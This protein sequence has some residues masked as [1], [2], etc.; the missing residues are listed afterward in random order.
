[1]YSYDPKSKVLEVKRIELPVDVNVDLTENLKKSYSDYLKIQLEEDLQYIAE[2]IQDAIG[3]EGK[4]KII[5]FEISEKTNFE[6]PVSTRPKTEKKKKGDMYYP[7]YVRF[8][9]NGEYVPYSEDYPILKIPYMDDF[10]VLNVDGKEKVLLSELKSLEDVSFQHK[11][12]ETQMAIVFPRTQLRIAL[13]ARNINLVLGKTKVPME[14][15]ALSMLRASGDDRDISDIMS[16]SRYKLIDAS[17]GYQLEETII[18]EMSKLGLPE[19]FMK[20]RYKMGTLRPRLNARLSIDRAIDEVLAKDVI[21]ART[22]GVMPKGT[23]LSTEEVKLLKQNFVNEIYVKYTPNVRGFNLGEDVP[24]L[25][26]PEGFYMSDD[27]K[28]YLGLVYENQFTTETLMI[29]S[30]IKKGTELTSELLDAISELGVDH[31]V[32]KKTKQPNAP[33]ITIPFYK[34]IVGNYT[35]QVK[36]FLIDVVTESMNL[37]EGMKA[38]DHFYY[39][40]IEEP[41][42]NVRVVENDYLNPHD[43]IALMSLLIEADQNPTLQEVQNRDESFL[44]KI[45]RTRETFS[46]ALC[47]AADKWTGIV[48][49]KRSSHQKLGLMFNTRNLTADAVSGVYYN[50]QRKFISELG[51][52]KK[53]LVTTE[54]LNPVSL[55][56]Q[57]NRVSTYTSS[58]SQVADTMRTLALPYYGRLDPYETPAGKRIG[59][60]NTLA[61]ACKVENAIPKTPYI[62]V[63]AEGN[64]R[65]LDFSRVHYMDAYEE[66]KYPIGDI[67]DVKFDKNGYLEDAMVTARVPS[68]GTSDK[69]VIETIPTQYLK[70]V[71]AH[72]EQHC[73]STTML[74]PF[75]AANDGVRVQYALNLIR[76]SLYVQESEPPRVMTP[77]YKDIF[78]YSDAYTITAKKSGVVL[79]ISSDT[80]LIQYDDGEEDSLEIPETKVSNK[81][82]ITMN[83]KVNVDE[84]FEKGDVLVDSPVSKN[85]YFSP[86]VQGFVVYMPFRGK[87][88]ED[89]IPISKRASHKLV[90]IE[91]QVFEKELKSSEMAE[92]HRF[93]IENNYPY[94]QPGGKIAEITKLRKNTLT[95]G[96]REPVYTKDEQGLLYAF[97]HEVDSSKGKT[98][99]KAEL[100]KFN[101]LQSGDKMSGR[102]GNKGITSQEFDNS[103]MPRFLNG[104]HADIVWNP[105]GTV[106]RMNV[107]QQLEAYLGFVGYL[108]DIQISSAAFNGAT[109]D[110]VRDLMKLVYDFANMSS[111]Q[112]VVNKHKG[113]FPNEFLARGV[114]RFDKFQEWKGCFNPNGTARLYNPKTGKLYEK[115]ITF[116]VTYILKVDHEVDHKIHARGGAFEEEYTRMQQQPPQGS[117]NAGGQKFGEMEAATLAAMGATSFLW[118]SFNHKSDHVE[119]RTNLTLEAMGLPPMYDDPSQFIPKT[120]ESFLIDMQA[121]GIKTESDIIPD[122]D[123]EYIASKTLPNIAAVLKK[124]N[125]LVNDRDLKKHR[126]NIA[127]EIADMDFDD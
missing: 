62:R 108:F 3:I 89:A 4:R 18:D 33:L 85:G 42:N 97:D 109:L 13:T 68:V 69:V 1:M 43:V 96:R 117:S 100:L 37:P 9:A 86:G 26:V 91:M 51:Q 127:A 44:K 19:S 122:L 31:I 59:L 32:I 103:E 95:I 21:L 29:N 83:F 14:K 74:V 47:A 121:M 63:V 35:I 48:R 77:M 54:D 104:E 20:K 107:G 73:C 30:K 87:N 52:T 40:G 90:S 5:T 53:L 93:Q 126:E 50:L 60:T 57:I 125:S 28:K 8:Y 110:D 79:D 99:Y 11:S 34:E 101:H 46:E 88:Y 65:R 12:S 70:F 56:S 94:I 119:Y 111:P 41:W 124:N 102:H 120:L 55:L 106:S 114:Q 17:K 16:N 115:P 61:A 39:Y 2:S 24:I 72:P 78:S 84:R 105:A 116:G 82:Y 49:D 6:V 81:C 25:A 67:L 98:T 38:D 112:E 22:G 66:A 23:P 92:F 15:L 10:C 118:E 71:S 123:E 36:D 45:N 27:F 75:A 113:N 7:V 76:Q 64:R 80:M 58:S